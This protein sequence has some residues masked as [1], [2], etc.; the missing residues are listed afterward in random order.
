M[1]FNAAAINCASGVVGR[2]I[3]RDST[4]E[5]GAPVSTAG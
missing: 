1:A 4:V 5:E 3:R 2:S